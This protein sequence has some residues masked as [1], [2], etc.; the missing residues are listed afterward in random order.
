MRPP[1][2]VEFLEAYENPMVKLA[3]KQAKKVLKKVKS[4]VAGGKDD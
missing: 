1:S 2:L 4:L 3:P